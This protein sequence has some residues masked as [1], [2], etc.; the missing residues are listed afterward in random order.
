MLHR[1]DVRDGE[2]WR[3]K[4]GPTKQPEMLTA[5]GWAPRRDLLRCPRGYSYRNMPPGAA[6]TASHLHLLLQVRWPSEGFLLRPDSTVTTDAPATA[7]IRGT[8]A[9]C[10]AR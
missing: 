1:C 4:I 8:A 5:F 3:A 6:P 2:G 10:N 7:A 9:A